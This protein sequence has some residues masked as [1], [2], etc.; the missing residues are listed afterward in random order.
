MKI[1]GH[2]LGYFLF[3]CFY[4]NLSCFFRTSVVLKG[5]FYYRDFFPEVQFAVSWVSK[6]NLGIIGSPKAL[7]V[8]LQMFAAK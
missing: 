3:L 7:K 5:C 6:R 2:H 1:G 8:F 4:R